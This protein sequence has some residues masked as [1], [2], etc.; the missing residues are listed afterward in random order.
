MSDIGSIII[1]VIVFRI[2]FL[3]LRAWWSGD[4]RND[5]RRDRQRNYLT[6]L[7]NLHIG[8]PPEPFQFVGDVIPILHGERTFAHHHN[9]H[10]DVVVGTI[11][12]CVPKAVAKVESMAFSSL[13]HVVTDLCRALH[14]QDTSLS[15]I[16]LYQLSENLLTIAFSSQFFPNC[17]VPIPVEG[18]PGID[19]GEAYELFAILIGGEVQWHFPNESHEVIPRN[20]LSFGKSSLIES[21]YLFISIGCCYLSCFHIYWWYCFQL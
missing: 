13:L 17:K 14:V 2:I 20:L 1:I 16:M 18:L 12:I 10:G 15:F 7:F 9:G 3:V 11:D 19:N 6:L 4:C 8:W 21:L 5:F